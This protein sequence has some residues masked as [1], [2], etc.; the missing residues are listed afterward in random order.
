MIFI[1]ALVAMVAAV[2][3]A[4]LKPTIS[5]TGVKQEK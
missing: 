1:A 4:L 5:E 3:A 2:S